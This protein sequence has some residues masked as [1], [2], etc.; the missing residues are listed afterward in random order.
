MPHCCSK[1]PRVTSLVKEIYDD[2]RKQFFCGLIGPLDILLALVTA[3]QLLASLML[4][5]PSRLPL[6]PGLEDG[7]VQGFF[8]KFLMGGTQN[9]RSPSVPDGDEVRW[10]GGLAKK[11]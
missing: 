6:L 7:G 8:S 3:H 2:M 4:I 11:I 1:L 10:G 5:L 9:F